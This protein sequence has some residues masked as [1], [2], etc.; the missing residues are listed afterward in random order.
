MRRL[1]STLWRSKAVAAV[2]S[3]SRSPHVF[4]TLLTSWFAHGLQNRTAGS[5]AN[6]GFKP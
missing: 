1:L 2:Q 6:L 3:S 4:P 5:F